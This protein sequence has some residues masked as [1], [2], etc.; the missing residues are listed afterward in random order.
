ME[1]YP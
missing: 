1:H